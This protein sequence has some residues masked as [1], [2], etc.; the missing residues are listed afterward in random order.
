M[1]EAVGDC[2]FGVARGDAV[3]P[4]CSRSGSMLLDRAVCRSGEV[5]AVAAVG[6][7]S[8]TADRS[9]GGGTSLS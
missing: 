4:I 2:N 8:G 1:P 7:N 9:A 6:I 3:P 5:K